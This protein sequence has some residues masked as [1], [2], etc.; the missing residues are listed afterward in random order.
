MFHFRGV[1]FGAGVVL[2]VILFR[3]TSTSLVLLYLSV[4][5]IIEPRCQQAAHG[6]SLFPPASAQVQL[7]RTAIVPS[8][9][10]AYPAL[11]LFQNQWR[12]SRDA[13]LR[14]VNITD[15]GMVQFMSARVDVMPD[16]ESQS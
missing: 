13:S 11:E 9:L 4:R 15:K 6:P 7:M 12:E 2:S 8:T 1:G 5:P 3:R 14:L 10:H 16:L